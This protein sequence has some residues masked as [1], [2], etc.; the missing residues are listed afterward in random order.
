MMT[1]ELFWGRWGPFCTF[2]LFGDI[3]PGQRGADMRQLMPRPTGDKIDD[4]MEARGGVCVA[5]CIEWIR[6]KK[7]AS[8][9]G[10]FKDSFSASKHGQA[11]KSLADFQ[12]LKELEAFQSAEG[13]DDLAR[14][15]KKLANRILPVQKNINWQKFQQMGPLF[16]EPESPES[17]R[18]FRLQS[19]E[20]LSE[21]TGLSI[22]TVGEA[23][24]IRWEGSGCK[25]Q[26]KNSWREA[27][28]R[29]IMSSIQE[30]IKLERKKEEIRRLDRWSPCYVIEFD[31]GVYGTGH[32]YMGKG[33]SGHAMG[34]Q[35][36][37]GSHEW[38]LDQNT[39]EFKFVLQKGED[40]LIRFFDDLWAAYRDI[41]HLQFR[42]WN[43]YQYYPK[44]K[45]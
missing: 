18:E 33:H 6:R 15:H 35:M 17:R 32:P 3:H 44:G 25:F 4:L 1:K 41:L 2:K 45:S 26:L 10:L 23:K 21:Y 31:G 42:G 16:S 40:M 36:V 13:L 37:E 30:L 20:S 5:L 34:F 38:F 11:A 8:K 19:F 9:S 39:G 29:N 22:R 27:T 28:G 43:L 14:M 24:E 7:H 12:S